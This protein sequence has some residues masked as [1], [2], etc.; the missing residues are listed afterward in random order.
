MNYKKALEL[1]RPGPFDYG[2]AAGV[3]IDSHGSTDVEI[4]LHEKLQIP[5]MLYRIRPTT[6]WILGRTNYESLKAIDNWQPIMPNTKMY[7]LI[8]EVVDMYSD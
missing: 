4:V 3:H 2:C 7:D 5:C 6:S 1:S 8:S